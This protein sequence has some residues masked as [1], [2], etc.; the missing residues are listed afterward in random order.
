MVDAAVIDESPTGKIGE[1]WEWSG[2]A[3][4]FGG[5]IGEQDR[6]GVDVQFICQWA[7]SIALQHGAEECAAGFDENGGGVVVAAEELECGAK[8][9]VGAGSLV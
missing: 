1:C 9:E 2:A 5:G 7:G 8:I 6:A 3:D 4:G